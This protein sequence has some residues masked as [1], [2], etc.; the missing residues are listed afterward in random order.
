MH[1]TS[2]YVYCTYLHGLHVYSPVH[3][4]FTFVYILYI[5]CSYLYC[6]Y[7]V[8]T[9]SQLLH[10]QSTF[11]LHTTIHDKRTTPNDTQDAATS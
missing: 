10:F 8:I 1:C 2:V 4:W 6:Y 7:I 3:V 5:H 11:H 9:S